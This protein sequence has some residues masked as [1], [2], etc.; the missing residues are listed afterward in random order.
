MGMIVRDALHEVS[1]ELTDE[2]VY[3]AASRFLLTGALLRNPIAALSEGQKWL[4]CYAR[5][6]LQEPHILIL[7]EPT[8]HINFRHLPVIAEA[9]NQYQ[10]ALIMVCHDVQ[11]LS[12]VQNIEKVELGKYI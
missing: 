3:R 4:L 5:F 8:N 11:F 12:Q 10:W 2:Q 6:V 1:N 7:D 9:L